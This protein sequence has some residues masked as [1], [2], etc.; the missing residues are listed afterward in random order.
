MNL[1]DLISRVLL[2]GL[3]SVN[4]SGE[5]PSD[6]DPA[7]IDTDLE[8][9]VE[10]M[11]DEQSNHHQDMDEFRLE[12]VDKNDIEYQVDTPN[13]L[14]EVGDY[15]DLK[16]RFI[17]RSNRAHYIKSFDIGTSWD[18]N[19]EII[20]TNL[21]VDRILDLESATSY[22][23]DLKLD[24]RSE[25][26]AL[27]RIKILESGSHATPIDIQLSDGHYLFTAAGVVVE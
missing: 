10:E 22:N 20:S 25:T 12:A 15:V 27:F 5:I 4:T 23:T 18:D 19:V 3:M 17:N 9:F 24:P 1:I 13:A 16:I 11:S 8:T 2:T 6:F 7:W 26:V 14:L 21:N